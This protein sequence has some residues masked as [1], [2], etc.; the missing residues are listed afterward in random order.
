MHTWEGA[1]LISLSQSHN[2]IRQRE[3]LFHTKKDTELSVGGKSLK[4][5]NYQVE[6]S[7]HRETT[8]NCSFVWH[9]NREKNFFNE[10]QNALLSRTE[11]SASKQKLYFYYHMGVKKW[12]S[13][14]QIV[15]YV[16]T[17]IEVSYAIGT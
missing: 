16:N 10:V 14:H 2:I 11:R 3:S 12:A 4:E 7:H 9:K 15:I 17:H 13:K 1:T 8:G 5:K 6:N